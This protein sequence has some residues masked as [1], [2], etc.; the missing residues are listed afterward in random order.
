MP[1]TTKRERVRKVYAI[2]WVDIAAP[3]EAWLNEVEVGKLKGPMFTTVG[4]ILRKDKR[5]LRVASTIDH[6]IQGT[7][8]HGEPRVVSDVNVIPIGA[9]V[10]CEFLGSILVRDD[11]KGKD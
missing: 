7:A 6:N 1:R 10:R 2:D 5:F 11:P 3:G 8:G 4:V 9:V